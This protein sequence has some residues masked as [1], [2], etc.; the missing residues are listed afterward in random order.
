[1][2]DA[3]G[4]GV[5]NWEV[6]ETLARQGDFDLFL[7]A[8]RYTLLEQEALASFLPLCEER[9]IGIILGGPYNSGI[10]ATGARPGA[11]YNYE[12]APPEVLDRVARIEEVCAAHGVR[13]IEA[14]LRFPLAHPCVVSVIPGGQT[15]AEWRA[16][17]EVMRAI[18]PA[19][20]WSDLKAQGLLRADAPTP[21]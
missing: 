14:A 2:V 10:L 7:L 12:P 19:A 21:T 18:I 8:G 6:C 1:V 4:A 11:T 20:L 9:G 16:N 17:A 13:L 5:N 15:D 3:I